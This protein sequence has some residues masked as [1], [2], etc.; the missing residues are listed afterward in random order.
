MRHHLEKR[1]AHRD[2]KYHQTALDREDER[3]GMEKHKGY[4][5]KES[6]AGHRYNE[7]AKHRKRESEGMK[8]YYREHNRGR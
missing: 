3:K 1:K 4:H 7:S 5:S 2:G 6:R 8:K